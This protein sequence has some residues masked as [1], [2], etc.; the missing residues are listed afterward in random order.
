MY[1]LVLSQLREQATHIPLSCKGDSW[2]ALF[3][4]SNLCK[5]SRLPSNSGSHRFVVDSSD[6]TGED[7][8]ELVPEIEEFLISYD[9]WIQCTHVSVGWRS[10][11]LK[12]LDE[13]VKLAEQISIE[14]A[15][16]EEEANHRFEKGYKINDLTQVRKGLKKSAYDVVNTAFNNWAREEGAWES[17][18]RNHMRTVTKLHN[19][20][21]KLKK[22]LATS[23]RDLELIEAFRHLE[24]LENEQATNLFQGARVFLRGLDWEH[25]VDGVGDSATI[26]SGFAALKQAESLIAACFGYGKL[27]QIPNYSQI[28]RILDAAM[29]KLASQINFVVSNIPGIDVALSF[30]S[31]GAKLIAIY[32]MS[33]RYSSVQTIENALPTGDAKSAVSAIKIWQQEYLHEQKKQAAMM[34]GTAGLNLAALLCPPGQPVARFAACAKAIKDTM[35]CIV[36]IANQVKQANELERYLATVT[37]I[38]GNIFKISPLVGAYYVLNASLS[39]ISRH[40]VPFTS[41]TFQADTEYLRRSGAI[42]D[43]LTDSEMLIA[44]SHFELR[45]KD[46]LMFR[47]SENMSNLTQLNLWAKQKTISASKL[48]N[49][50]ATKLD[51]AADSVSEWYNKKSA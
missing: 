37:K 18:R 22:E 26:G 46:G 35:D 34:A 41:P 14:I 50:A 33:N 25:T 30:A 3:Q 19:R 17:S 15:F 39:T 7:G 31:V 42:F 1:C 49:K 5:M 48:Y 51:A 36:K 47:K 4:E 24:E 2:L 38:D 45:P 16:V 23:P 9:E 8:F 13:A 27:I 28:Q 44:Q 29:P 21:G 43:L 32:K 12:K 11:T 6:V 40:L 10:G 20:L